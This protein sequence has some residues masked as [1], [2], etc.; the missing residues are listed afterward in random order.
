MAAA[1]EV[2]A[3]SALVVYFDH[4]ALAYVPGPIS[5]RGAI[6]HLVTLDPMAVDACLQH[7]PDVTAIRHSSVAINIRTQFDTAVASHGLKHPRRVE[8]CVSLGRGIGL[9]GVTRSGRRD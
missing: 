3:D 7:L 2:V 8:V 6:D 5:R 1:A 4:K 9:R